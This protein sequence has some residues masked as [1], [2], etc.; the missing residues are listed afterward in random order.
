VR[1]S[2]GGFGTPFFSSDVEIR[3]QGSDLIVQQGE[4]ER[5]APITTLAAAAAH[6]GNEIGTAAGDD[7][8]LPVD[9]GAAAFLGEW[10]G[11]CGPGALTLPSNSAARIAGRAPPTASRR[12][13]TPTPTPMSTWRPGSSRSPA[14]C[15]RRAASS[16]AEL[17]YAELLGAED[18]RAAALEFLRTRMSA[19]AR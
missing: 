2:R 10:Y 17:S 1:R 15:G 14:N 18:Q 4:A 11:F 16:G 5:P 8:P 3:V 9:S 13:T 19:L 7:S 12:A 6:L